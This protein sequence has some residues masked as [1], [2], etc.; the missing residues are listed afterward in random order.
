MGQGQYEEQYKHHLT[1]M[2][3]MYI[4]HQNEIAR[5]TAEGNAELAKM[6]HHMLQILF[7]MSGL[8][9]G[10]GLYSILLK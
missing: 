4:N 8:V 7:A 6:Q 1:R 10:V 2:V 5:I 9:I 3:N